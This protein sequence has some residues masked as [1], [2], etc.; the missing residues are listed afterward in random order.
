VY[1]RLLKPTDRS[2]F[3]FGPRGTGKTAWLKEQLTDALTFDL[4]QS[5]VHQRFAAAPDRLGDLVPERY[6]GWVVLDEIQRVPELLNEVHRLIE[7]RKLRFAMTGSSARKLRRQGINLLA[8]RAR[9]LRMHPLSALELGK[10]FDLKRGVQYGALPFACTTKDP[11]AYLGDYVGTYLREEV[12]QEALVRDVGSFSRFLEAASLSQG[13]VLNM[14]AVA[15]EC[16]VSAK[17]AENFFQLAEDL[18]LSVRIPAFTKRA[19]RRLVA[20][21]K[22]Y[23]FD[24]GVY[25]TVRPKGPLDS[26][27]EIDGAALETLLLSNL[28]AINDAYELGYTLH[29][30]RTQRGAEVDFV[31]YGERGLIAIEV[32]RNE[33]LRDGDLDGLLA[34]L[35]DYPMAKAFLVHPGTRREHLRGV[36]VM[37]IPI[38]LGTLDALLA[39]KKPLPRRK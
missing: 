1:S 12:Q 15:R 22:F 18:L 21:P 35:A 36:E 31:L 23:F 32:K 30:W 33:R 3:L 13:S 14:A 9:T 24:A 25:R 11:A 26:D 38:M 5:S 16:A 6:K 19:K 10:D 20:H 28:R 8:G 17:V 37:P 34:F 7:G 39:G 2:F 29:Y 27:E 4:L